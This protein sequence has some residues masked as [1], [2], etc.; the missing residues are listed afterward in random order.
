MCKFKLLH[1]YYTSQLFSQTVL[2]GSL[3]GLSIS[4]LSILQTP[5]VQGWKRKMICGRGATI[6][7]LGWRGWAIM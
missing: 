7:N 4:S 5:F 1:N 6:H 2:A 3:F